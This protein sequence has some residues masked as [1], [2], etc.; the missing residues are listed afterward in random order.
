M[1]SIFGD[2]L[3]YFDVLGKEMV[4]FISDDVFMNMLKY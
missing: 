3:W 1:G 4:L 2:S